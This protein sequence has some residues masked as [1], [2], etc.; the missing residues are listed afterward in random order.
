MKRIFTLALLALTLGTV[1]ANAQE[2]RKTWDF[3]T[4]FSQKTVNALKGDQEEFGDSKYWRNYESDATKADEQH[5][6]NASRDARNSDLYACTH[7]GGMEK[8][9]PELEGLK[10]GMS[11]AKKFV[12]TYNG[13][14]YPNEF[15]AEG[16]PAI[17]EPIPHGNSYVW[18]NGKNETITFQAKVNQTIKIGVESHAVNRSKLGEARGISLSTSVGSLEL[19]SGN[20]VPVY[21]TECEWELTGD[22]GAVA[23]VQLKTTNGCHIYYIIVGEGDDVNANKTKVAYITDGEGTTEA[24]YQTLAA[25]ETMNVAVLDVNSMATFSPDQLAGYDVTVISPAIAADNAIVSLLKPAI[26]FYPIVNLNSELYAAWGYGE[27]I[28]T[29]LPIAL[30]NDTK[31]GLFSGFGEGDFDKDGDNDIVAI[32]EAS[33]LQAVH[34]GDYFTGDDMPLV[35]GLD[36]TAAL[37]H[38]HNTYHNAY[39]YLAFADDATEVGKKLL[40]NAIDMAK[41]SKSEIT[42]A[43]APKIVMEYKNMNTNITL[44]MASSALPQPH[45]YYTLDGS[46]PTEASTEYSD[47]INVSGPCTVKAVAIADGYLLSDVA[48]AQVEIFAQ[49]ETP[50]ISCDYQDGKTV[51]TLECATPDV[52]VWYSFNTAEAAD[53]TLSMKYTEPF[54]VAL[55]TDFTA[56]SVAGKQVFSELAQKRIVVK[57]AKVRQDQLGVFDSNAADWQ[58]GGS[59]STIYYFS[60][61]K[62]ARSIYDTTQDPIGTVVD[63]ETGDETPIYPELDYEYYAPLNDEGDAFR[64]DWEVKSKGQVM[65]WQ[66]LSVG[67]D[68]GNGEGYNP[69]T[70]GDI[71]P[72][73][74]ATN[75]DIQFG[76][77][78]SGEPCTGA[79]QSLKKFQGPFDVVTIVGTAAGGDNMGRMQ[80]EVS[81]DSVEWTK[82]G[83]EMLTSKTKRLWKSYTRSYDEADEVYVRVIQAGGGSSVQIYNIYI[84]NEGE[85]SVALKQQYDEEFAN[86]GEDQGISDLSAKKVAAGVYNL[87]GMRLKGASHGLNIVVGTDGSVKKVV[88]K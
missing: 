71:I 42:K 38:I 27:A 61:G 45:I 46:D 57:N 83:D 47:V 64:G 3:R 26:A 73:A 2:L 84:L 25:D 44:A 87:N 43:P 62:N 65:I 19:T 32:S 35:D 4:G 81:K 20:P 7:N 36:P 52:D 14:T 78:T 18:L 85:N 1:G 77:K 80:L 11:N 67:S 68:P 59:G 21:Y 72:Y 53:T 69:E 76:G 86:S 5:Y 39:I 88:V 60:W 12:I 34:L 6:W 17:G 48:E 82:L 16:G 55:P 63:E 56:F 49:P 74:K 70:T 8:V 22:E 54:A 50:S 66:N 40:F 58:K 33:S 79:I 15:E 29:G 75:H 9:I 30:V 23:D 51:V 31:N 13:A 37:A 41:G 24:A 10:L 28:P